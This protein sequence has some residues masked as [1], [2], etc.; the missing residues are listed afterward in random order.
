MRPSFLPERRV[1][2]G[3]P[4]GERGVGALARMPHELARDV[5]VSRREALRPFLLP[6]DRQSFLQAAAAMALAVTDLAALAAALVLALTVRVKMLPLLAPVFPPGLPPSLGEHL[7]WVLAACILCLAYEGLYTQRLPF[8]RE[9]RRLVKALTMAFLLVIAVTFLGKISGEFSRTVLVLSYIVALVLLPLG[10]L[11][12]KSIMARLGLWAQPVL[13][14]G[15]GKTGELVAGA[16]LRDKYLGCRIAGFLDDDPAKKARGVQVNG[17]H[18]PVLG[19]FRDSDRVMAQT[20]ARDLIVAAPGMD[21]KVL[22][23][24]VNRLQ[25]TARSVLVVPDLFGLP[26]VGAR[27]EYFFE[28]QAIAFR[29]HNNLASPWNMFV[30]RAFDL[31]AGTVILLLALP[32]M[33]AVAVA[34]KCDSPGPVIFTHRRIGRWGREFKCYKFRT[35]YLN[36]EEILRQYLASN[37]AAREE[38]EK[39]AKLKGCDPRVTRVGRLLRKFSLDELPQIFN[40]LKGEMSLAG[41]RPYLPRER[42]RMGNYAETILL[43]RPGITGLWQVGGRNEI[44]FE[45][46]LRLES[47]Y[48]RNWSLWLDITIL[49]RTAGVVLARRGAY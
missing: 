28:E 39:Y 32:L 33:A 38:W 27:A 7:W 34:I 5:L 36:N 19:G 26:V 3:G 25:R 48:V 35:M 44:D 1:P 20:G 12:A 23:G 15:A 10:R 46:R 41:P 6:G 43:A 22:V 11:A 45:G 2:A 8:W 4:A 21:P 29:V 13:I 47:W 18:F 30:K 31:A 37:P 16:L 14:L 40:V 49:I 24:L 42:L 17:I 9:A